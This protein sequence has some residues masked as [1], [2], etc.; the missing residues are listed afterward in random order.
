[1]NVFISWSGTKSR[2]VAAALRQW[3]PAVLPTSEPW[4]ASELPAGSDWSR[5]I[6]HRLQQA[7]IGIICL[8]EDNK[9]SPWLLFE[10]G[11]LARAGRLH[12]YLIDLPAAELAGPLAQFQAA[13]ADRDGTWQLIAALNHAA[14][15]KVPENVLRA[16]FDHSWPQLQHALVAASAPR[17]ETVSVVFAD[18]VGSTRLIATGGDLA[19]RQTFQEFIARAREFLRLHKGRSFKF[20][21][22]GFLATF[23][24]PNDAFIFASELQRSLSERPFLIGG[25]PL[26]VRMGLHC[27]VVHLMPTSHGE[28]DIA[29]SAINLAA[30]ITSMANPGQIVVSGDASAQ[31]PN[32][33]RRLLSPMEQAE[34]KGYADRVEVSRYSP[35]GTN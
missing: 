29:G 27:G 18:V 20:V 9:D 21:G 26:T 13:R 2:E 17:V 14:E 32:E 24:T 23:P 11:A 16:Q 8:T 25:L 12:L 19:V 1:M 30:R 4:I 22:D 34:V 15:G 6:T 28:E 3:I 33:L 5:E 7:R 35:T 10:A 31:L